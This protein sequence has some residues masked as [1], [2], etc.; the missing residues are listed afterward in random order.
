MKPWAHRMQCRYF[1]HYV[2]VCTNLINNCIQLLVMDYVV[3]DRLFERNN[4]LREN[5]MRPW[6]CLREVIPIVLMFDPSSC[7]SAGWCCTLTCWCLRSVSFPWWS[8]RGSA[9]LFRRSLFRSRFFAGGPAFVPHHTIEPRTRSS[10][11]RCCC[12]TKASDS[13]S[14]PL[15]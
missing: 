5:V 9:C 14:C 12:C 4:W 15:T 13:A 6:R 2:S 11:W 7:F 8:F 1:S 3:T 10:P